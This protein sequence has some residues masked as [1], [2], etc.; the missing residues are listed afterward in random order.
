LLNALSDYIPPGERIITIEDSAELQICGRD[1]LV[2]LEARNANTEGKGKI[3]IRDLI[4]ASL[5]MRPDRIVIGEVRGD[6][7]VDLLQV[8]NTGHEGSLCTGHA[9]SGEDML[10]RLE[11]MVLCASNI[12]L[13][14]VRRQIASAIDIIIHLERNEK[15]E[16]RIVTIDEV[17][18]YSE[19]KVALHRIF[20]FRKDNSERAEIQNRKKAVRI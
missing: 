12:P 4:K 2:R 3:T 7:A 10:S 8:M 20:R 19:G 18:G 16:R 1:N 17:C 14:A 13:E 15:M 11:T 5:R 9:N 6:E